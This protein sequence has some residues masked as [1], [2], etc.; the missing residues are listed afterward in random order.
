MKAFKFQI[1]LRVKNIKKKEVVKQSICNQSTSIL[2]LNQLLI[3]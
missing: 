2:K 3:I 1:T